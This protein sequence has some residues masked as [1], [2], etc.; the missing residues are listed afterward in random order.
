[1]H[2]R[3]KILT[4]S[5]FVHNLCSTADAVYELSDLSE[6]LQRKNT[7]MPQADKAVRTTIKTFESMVTNP[8]P[9]FSKAYVATETGITITEMGKLQ[10]INCRKFLEVLQINFEVN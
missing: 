1:M 4:N 8:E 9:N 5:N 6:F 3:L 7:T 10:P 2:E